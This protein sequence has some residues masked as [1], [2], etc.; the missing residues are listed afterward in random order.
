VPFT[1][2]IT[3]GVL[4]TPVDKN[5][6]NTSGTVTLKPGRYLINMMIGAY[7]NSAVNNPVNMVLKGNGAT[8][9]VS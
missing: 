7:Y 6:N 3:P 8:G 2:L 9:E 1:Q 5:I 4:S